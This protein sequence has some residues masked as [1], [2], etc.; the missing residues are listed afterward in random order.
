MDTRNRPYVSL[1]RI[2]V[3]SLGNCGVGKVSSFV[4]L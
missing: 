2:R 1:P 3:L 4:V